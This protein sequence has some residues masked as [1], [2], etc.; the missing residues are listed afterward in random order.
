MESPDGL[1]LNP[2]FEDLSNPSS[3]RAY[4]FAGLAAEGFDSDFLNSLSDDF[5]I[6][7]P[8]ARV[9]PWRGL[10]FFSDPC[11]RPRP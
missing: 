8:V 3:F 1:D 4:G 10:V 7:F 2:D 6:T 5:L 9:R 11:L